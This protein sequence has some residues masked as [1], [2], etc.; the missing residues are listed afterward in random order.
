MK[1]PATLLNRFRNH[2]GGRL[3]ARSGSV[4]DVVTFASI[5]LCTMS[6]PGILPAWISA[7]GTALL[8]TLVLGTAVFTLNCLI[9]TEPIR[10]SQKAGKAAFVNMEQEHD[11]TKVGQ[12]RMGVLL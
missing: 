7:C 9:G 3:K 2:T 11:D 5:S 4:I 10:E 12:E 1:T 8:L 6:A